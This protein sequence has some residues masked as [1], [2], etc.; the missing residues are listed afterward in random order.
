MKKTIAILSVLA[1]T[2]IATPNSNAE[3]CSALCM[4]LLSTTN[5]STPLEARKTALE[6]AKSNYLQNLENIETES[7]LMNQT[8]PSKISVSPSRS[9]R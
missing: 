3:N 1:L 2:M 7:T 4:Q 6:R 5:L 8:R 9:S